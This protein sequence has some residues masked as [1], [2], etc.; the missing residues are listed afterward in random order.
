MK[1]KISLCPG[2]GREGLVLITSFILFMSW[3]L[4]CSLFLVTVIL[5]KN[6]PTE[7]VES[8]PFIEFEQIVFLVSRSFIEN[9]CRNV[10]FSGLGSLPNFASNI[11]PVGNYMFKINNKNTRTR[12]EI[13]SKLTIKTT[14]RRQWRRSGCLYCQ[15]WTYSMPCSSVSIVNF[16]QANAGWEAKLSKLTKFF[17]PFYSL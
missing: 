16:E 6:V 15:L 1:I 3:N 11:N 5:D 13:C 8:K 12:H 7:L 2:L 4:W 17:F 14:E 10:S 9:S